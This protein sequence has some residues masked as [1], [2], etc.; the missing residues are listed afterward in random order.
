[1]QLA[2]IDLIII[3]I[4]IL[5]LLLIGF[6][7]SKKSKAGGIPENDEEYLL[8]GRKVTLPFFVATLVATWYG[9][10]LGVGEFVYRG[11]IVAWVSFGLPYYLAAALFAF[12]VAGK[13]RKL[14]VR[15]IPE[16]ITA[17]YGRKAGWFSSIIIL[18]VSLPAVYVLMLGIFIQMF[19]GWNLLICI[20]LGALITLVFVYTGG[21][22]ADIYTNFFQFFLMYIGFFAFAYFAISTLG[23]PSE[24][25][26]KLP[27]TH[28]SLKGPYSLQYILVWYILALQ[29]FIDPSF[30]QRSAAAKSPSTAKFGILISIL[31]WA[32]F[33]SLTLLTGLYAKAYIQLDNPIMAFPTLGNTIMPA[34]W[35]GVLVISMLSV[36]MS[37]LESY[38]F[39]SAATIG[40]D[41]LAPLQAKFRLNRIYSIK[42]LTRAGFIISSVFSI[43]LASS[44][45]ST[46]DL[47]YKT[48]SIAVP[49][50][51]APM[52]IS[53]KRNYTIEQKRVIFIMLASSGTSALWTLF[54]YFSIRYKYLNLQWLNNIEPMFSGIILSFI[55]AAIFVKKTDA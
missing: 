7:S 51:L 41:I 37:T 18:I 14:E 25:L 45:T 47:V 38:T 3:L 11:G 35:K 36:I 40:N 20:T 4:Y 54:S 29:T 23:S 17:K 53:F 46:I 13:I 31:C 24:M 10:I 48:A 32:L 9:N 49:G 30:H 1:M 2:A 39:L 52:L 42:T 6:Y 12:F 26:K 22:K 16:Q 34:F 5:F 15:T 33:D 8:A 27:E 19:F 28:L 21:L 44:V 50:L 43:I 55:L